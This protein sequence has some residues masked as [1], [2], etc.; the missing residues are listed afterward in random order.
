MLSLQ[1][2]QQNDS[3]KSNLKKT[4]DFMDTNGYFESRECNIYEGLKRSIQ[5]E[6][7]ETLKHVNLAMLLSYVKK[8][9]IKEY[10]TSTTLTT[11]TLG[12]GGINYLVPTYM[13][14]K[15]Y[16][17]A[18]AQDIAPAVSADVIMDQPGDTLNLTAIVR[19][20]TVK[21]STGSTGGA[22]I[23]GSEVKME[24][25]TSPAIA[26]TEMIED[27]D[28]SL[29]ETLTKA[30]G[31]SMVKQSNDQI[32]A[33]LKRVT[34]TLGFG[35]KTVEAAG[36]DT[37][38]PANVAACAQEVAAGAAGIGIYHPNVLVCPPEVWFD[39]LTTTTGHP[40]IH[41]PRNNQYYAWYSGLDVV[42]INSL[43]LGTVASNKL[44]NAVSIILEKECGIVTAR[45]NWLRIE[46]YSD[47]V[48]DL[49][50][51]FISGRQ[52]CGEL[53]DAA[54]GVLTES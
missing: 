23:R 14:Q 31:I 39:A 29:I 32:L 16:V 51:A 12:A 19:A 48:K 9:S 45:K 8:E 41:P 21:G 46:N 49:A 28:Y 17:A 34:G 2:I 6:L 38:T 24:R 7:A 13:T 54:I 10:V 1:E 50:G 3:I 36:A 35:D 26:T 4:E 5:R 47:P 25:F 11:G 27:N 20:L 44:T 37:T 18:T 52:S 43:Q 15:L 42:Q 40:D 22:T 30:A 53:V 33:V